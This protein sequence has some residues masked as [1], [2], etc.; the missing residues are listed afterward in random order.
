MK[1]TFVYPDYFE[2]QDVHVE[3]QGRVYLGIGYLSSVL[4]RGGHSVELI[5]IIEPTP[6]DELVEAVRGSHPDLVAMS[7][8]TLQFSRAARIA[9]WVKEDLGLPVV[10]GGV[11][12]TIAP[13]DAISEESIDYICVGEGEGAL[14]ELCDALEAGRSAEGIGS[15]WYKR[16]G[17]P[18]RN[19]VRPLVE[20][21]DTI[22]FPDR[23]IFDAEKFAGNQVGR[24]SMMASRGC[25]FDC[26]YC[27]NHLQRR[28]YPNGRKY[29]RFR[30]PGNVIEE[31]E[32]ARLADP[33]IRQVRFEDDILTM[34]RGWFRK[35]AALYEDRVDL[36]YICNARVDLLNE[37]MVELLARSGCSTVAMGI[38]SGN[39]W[40]RKNVLGRP[41]D[42]DRILRAF[43]LCHA[44]GIKTVSLNMV[45]F[46]HETLSMALDTVKM[47]AA[48]SP[49]LAQ[50]T[51]LCP[52][53]NTRIHQVC[54]EAGMI[55]DATPDT[56]FSG[57]SQLALDGMSS[58][59]VRMVCENIVL[60]MVAYRRCSRLPSPLSKMATALLDFLLGT[61]LVPGGLRDRAL[62]KGRYRLDWKHFIGVDY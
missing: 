18:R 45:G 61:R 55:G 20:D 51:A 53:P 16:G 22:P 29:V 17:E 24:L 54:L 8:T 37:E 47:N 21:I 44:A 19:P 12:P 1:V 26:S 58:A 11:H 4:K 50:I 25:P 23:S 52:F 30:S 35:F 36:P 33:G 62:E 28:V 34:D 56:I 27:C 39:R 57:R 59:Q 13:E 31:I 38:E 7:A 41:M 42:D 10:C 6:R 2:T 60:L 15:I 46:P 5:H 40:L 9:G 3:P 32:S 49:G 48:V 43:E 14:L